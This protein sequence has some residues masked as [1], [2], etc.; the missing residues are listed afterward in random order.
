M[1]K[2][3]IILF[4]LL[5]LLLPNIDAEFTSTTEGDGKTVCQGT[6]GVFTIFVEGS[7]NININKEGTASSFTTIVPSGL[8]LNVNKKPVFIY[9]TPSSKVQPGAYTLNL[10]VNDGSLEKVLPLKVNV[11]DCTT[12]EISG[13]TEKE[14][15]GC[16]SQQ[17]EFEIKNTG[18]Y[19]ETYSLSI[20]GEAKEFV[21]LNKNEIKLDPGK[22]AKV[23]AIVK[24]PC[25]TFGV[26]G[27]SLNIESK[28][29]NSIATID[30][31]IKINNCFDYNAVASTELVEMCERTKEEVQLTIENTADKSNMYKI[32]VVGPAWAN[33][34][35]KEIAVNAKDSETTALVLTPDYKVEGSFDIELKLEDANGK[36]RKDKIIKAN[37]KKCHDASLDIANPVETVCQTIQRE[38]PVFLKNTGEFDKIFGLDS[39]TEWASVSEKRISIDSSDEKEVALKL[40]PNEEVKPGKYTITLKLSSLDNSNIEKEDAIEI[41]VITVNDC[42]QP[43]VESESVVDVA[44][45]STTTSALTITNNG[46]EKADYE[47]SI[48]GTASSFVQLNPSIITIEPKKSEIIQLYIAPTVRVEK[49]EYKIKLTIKEKGSNVLEEKDMTVNVKE[50]SEIKNQEVNKS[51]NTITGKFF[52]LFKSQESYNELKEFKQETII[53][54]STE[55]KLKGEDH[56]LSIEEVRKDS[57][58]LK[59]ISDPVIVVLFLN[60]V[61]EVDIDN[62]K[63][64]D[65]K[66][67][68]ESIE[69]GIPTIKVVETNT[70]TTTE[71]DKSGFFSRNRNWI[72]GAIIVVILIILASIFLS[73]DEDEKEAK[74]ET[75]EEK[76]KVGRYI[77]TVIAIGVIAWLLSKYSLL[78][79]IDLYKYYIIIGLLI[80]LILVVVMKYWEEISSFFEEEYEEEKKEETEHPEKKEEKHPVKKETKEVKEKKAVKK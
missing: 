13:I 47:L 51:T 25:N 74:E 15:C 14:V 57:V 40:A 80:L 34:E 19:Q 2:R 49:G 36:I 24:A 69:N 62:D 41:N 58:T 20:K 44:A 4:I 32:S 29:S 65:L 55:F 59:I 7:G 26:K 11:K 72:I 35:K 68:L 21:E 61:K 53:K 39:D 71:P 42:Y 8:I 10:K 48:T 38:V 45:D 28:T 67:S 52:N 75:E 22:S 16:E 12:F 73:E 46:V 63:I 9:V 56:T 31:S 6:T 50:V 64:S 60:D 77:L 5:M 70:N 33:L 18:I 78:A 1:K 66:L 43:S 23:I 3:I 27:F 79:Q 37:I 54:E 17:S 76:I 30:N